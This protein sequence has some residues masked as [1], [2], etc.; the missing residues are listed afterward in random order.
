MKNKSLTCIK[1][2]KIILPDKVLTDQVLIF[3]EKIRE[4]IS[5]KDFLKYTFDSSLNV[6]DACGQYVSP[7]FIDIHIHGFGGVDTMDGSADILCTMARKIAQNGVTGFLPT[8]MSMEKEKVIRSLNAIRLAMKRDLKGAQILG[9]HMEGPFIS[10][11]RKGAHN[12]EFIVRPDFELI[13]T[14]RDVIKVITMAPEEDAGFNFIKRIKEDFDIVLSI[15]HTNADYET[16]MQAILGGVE[17]ATHLFNA[18]AP[19]HHRAPGP[20]G[21]V[22]NSDISFE[23]IA[24]TLHVHPGWF[25]IL[26]NAKGR[27]KMILVTDSMRAGGMH[28]GEWDLGG[29]SVFTDEYSA[30]LEDGTLAGSI[31]RMNQAVYNLLKYT[32]L[33]MHEAVATAS[34]NPA[35]LIRVSQNKGSITIGKDAD[36]IIFDDKINVDRTFCSGEIIRCCPGE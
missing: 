21:A 22:L 28:P 14:Y 29:Q 19:L 16:A 4:I 10:P 34:M 25:Q 5:E 6:I 9:A 13:E 33:K 24:D 2:G 35:K 12:K 20:A 31:L 36:I 17:S 8:T 18:M 30:R 27:D 15:G 1:G 26:L 3:D 23:L 11:I 32:D 7:G